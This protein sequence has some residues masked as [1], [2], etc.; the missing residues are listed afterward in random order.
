VALNRAVALAEV[1]GPA[2]A[3]RAIE[4]LDLQTYHLYHATRADLL[5]RLGRHQEAV[6]AY[7]A[8]IW[9]ATNAAERDFLR[10]RRLAREPAAGCRGTTP[11]PVAPADAGS[12][13]DRSPAGK[14]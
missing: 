13:G 7:D 14:D 12:P 6:L 10:R 8:A 4:D 1:A 3:L 11:A 2:T 9:L 5:A